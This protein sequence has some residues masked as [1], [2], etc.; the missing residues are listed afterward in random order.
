MPTSLH[1]QISCAAAAEGVSMNQFICVV[2]AGT[3]GWTSS[4]GGK[5]ESQAIQS[6]DEIVWEMLRRRLA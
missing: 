5:E 6:K 2:L 3:V 1:R 4:A